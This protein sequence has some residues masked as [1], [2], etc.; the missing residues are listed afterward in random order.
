MAAA[1]TNHTADHRPRSARDTVIDLPRLATQ[2]LAAVSVV[3]VAAVDEAGQVWIDAGRG[4][5]IAARRTCSVTVAD[6][7]REA[8]V[9]YEQ[10]D[11]DRPI[12]TGLLE[13]GPVVERPTHVDVDGRRITV[14]AQDELVLRCGEASITLTAAGKVLIRGNYVVSRSQGAN[15]IKGASVEIN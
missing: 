11:P 13:S 14:A 3:R 4:Q 6:A 5:A 15:H 2:S 8:I 12:V 1:Q 7:G 10:G 9:V